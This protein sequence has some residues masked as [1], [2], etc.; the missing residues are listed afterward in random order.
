MA[1]TTPPTRANGDVVTAGIW[2]QDIKDN[3]VYLK[4]LSTHV[5]GGYVTRSGANLLFA[6]DQSNRVRCYEGSEWVEKTI[7][8]A[9]ITVAC[10]GLTAD[11][12]YYLYVYDSSG[13]LTLE[14]SQTAPTTQNGIS[15]KNGSTSRT[16]IARCRTNASGAI[17][18]YNDDASTQLVC[19]AYNRRVIALVKTESTDSWSYSSTAIRALNNSASNRV[20]FVSSGVDAVHARAQAAVFSAT[21]T[22]TVGIGLDGTGADDSTV[23]HRGGALSGTLDTTTAEYAAVPAAGFHYLQIVEHNGSASALTWY[24]DNGATADTQTGI[25]A[26]VMA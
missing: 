9:G 17:T 4:G 5:S 12:D 25:V 3:S 10:T 21:V 26:V 14:R 13:T 7:P 15:V 16:T 18:T 22:G 19:N 1:W 6:P 24:G 23:R 20:Q 2:N 8:D 11:T